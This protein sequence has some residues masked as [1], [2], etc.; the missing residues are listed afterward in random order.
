M[1]I[2]LEKLKTVYN[3]EDDTHNDK[4]A[5]FAQKL[6]ELRRKQIKEKEK[7]HGENILTI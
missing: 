1:V 6:I 7:N 4:N 5:K 2:S 3:R